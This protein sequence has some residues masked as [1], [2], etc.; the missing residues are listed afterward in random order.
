[1]EIKILIISPPRNDSSWYSVYFILSLFF[2]AYINNV[3]SSM[4]C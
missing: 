1:M 4:K 2:Y 3:F